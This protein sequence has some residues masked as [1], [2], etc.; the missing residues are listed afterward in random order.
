MDVI[1]GVY[2][3]SFGVVIAITN[4]DIL[5]KGKQIHVMSYVVTM[6]YEIE[7][8]TIGN[9]RLYKITMLR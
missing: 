7:P 5:K 1:N 8:Y 2:F 4:G 3:K 6:H 9:N